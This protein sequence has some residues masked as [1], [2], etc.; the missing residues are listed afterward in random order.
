MNTANTIAS[1]SL[2][3]LIDNNLNIGLILIGLLKIYFAGKFF[4]ASITTS[5]FC[6]PWL[7][8]YAC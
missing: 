8:T 3:F 2:N 7:I 1:K 5:G 6:T 4:I